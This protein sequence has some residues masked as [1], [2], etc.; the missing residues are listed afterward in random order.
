MIALNVSSGESSI[1]PIDR[2]DVRLS[3]R[4]RS[5]CRLFWSKDHRGPRDC[6]AYEELGF[7]RRSSG[8]VHDRRRLARCNRRRQ[9][10][11]RRRRRQQLEHRQQLESNGVPGTGDDVTIA[12][13]NTV[14]LNTNTASLKSLTITGGTLTANAPS[15]ITT[16]STFAV[17]GGTFKGS[18][19]DIT[20]GG[21]LSISGAGTSFTFSSGTTS[22]AG[23]Y[24]MSATGG[25]TFDPNG[26]TLSLLGTGTQS[27]TFGTKTLNRVTIGAD[28]GLV[29]Y[30][31][32]DETSGA[33]I[34]DS[35]GSG[36]NGSLAGGFGR[37]TPPPAVTFTDTEA[38]TFDGTAY[39]TLGVTG[40]PANNAPQSMSAWINLTS[41]AGVQNFV[42]LINGSSA[43]QLGIRNDMY[44]P[45]SPTPC[46]DVWAFGGIQLA[47][48]ALP[49]TGVWHHVAYTFDGTT[50]RIYMDGVAGTSTTT[51]P[52]T[53]TPSQVFLGSYNGTAEFL[54]GALD[55]VRV[56]NRALSP[57]E[58]STLAGGSDLNGGA[59]RTQT[60]TDAFSSSDD[61]VINVGTVT[62]TSALS[63][64]GSWINHGIFTGTGAVTLTGTLAG[65]AI[66]SNGSQFTSLTVN[67][68]GGTYAVID[69]LVVTGS[70]TIASGAAMGGAGTI[71]VGG[72]WAN[73][74]TFSGTGTVTLTGSGTVKSNG[75]RFA[76]LTIATATSSTYTT[77]DRLWVPGGTVTLTSGTLAAVANGARVG[78]FSGAGTFTNSGTLT[79][80]GASNQSL[81]FPS[82]GGALRMEDTTETGLVAYWKLDAGLGNQ[83]YDF[84]GNGNNGTLSTSGTSWQTGVGL[85]TFGFEN[86]AS[87]VFDGTTGSGSIPAATIPKNSAAQTVSFWMNPASVAGTE[88]VVVF[89]NSTTGDGIKIGIQGSKVTVW[90]YGGG[91]TLIQGSTTLTTGTWYHVVYTYDGANSQGLYVTPFTAGVPGTITTTT[92]TAANP[93][94]TPSYAH[95]GT[96]AT[97]NEL[98][99]GALD[100]VRV[101]STVLTAAQISQ[102]LLGNYAGTGGT[103]P[104]YTPSATTTVTG[105]LFVDN[106]LLDDSGKTITANGGLTVNTGG[107]LTLAA[108]SVVS[109]ASGKTLA[110]DGT[111][112]ASST[113]AIQAGSGHFTFKVGS[114]TSVTPTLNISGLTVKGTTGGMQI[115][116]STSATTTITQLNNLKFSGG[117]GAQYLLINAKSAYLTS[118]GCSFDAGLA[119]GA[120]TKA[121]TLAGNGTA[122][123]ETRAVFG[124][125]TC[126]KNWAISASDTVCTTTA[127]SDDDAD[128]NGI[129]DNP[130]TN[131]AVAQMIRAAE[132]DT[133]GSVVGFP[134]AA[135]D[136]NTF[137]YYSTYAAF[138]NASSGSADVIYVRDESGTPL[139][140]WTVPIAGETITGTPLWT[141]SGST[142]YLY[143][144]TSAGHV[145]RLIDT[146]TG[147]TS[148]TLSL[149]T[150]GVVAGVGWSTNPF[151]CSCTISTPLTMDASNLYWG[152]TTSDKSFWT[153]GQSTES[154]PTPVAITQTVTSTGLSV[155]NLSATT[156]YAFM[157][158]SGNFL[159]IDTLAQT[160]S[161]ANSS[162]GGASINGRVV[163]GYNKTGTWRAYGG[164]SSGT[165]WAL[166]PGAGFAT[167]NGLWSYP[168]GNAIQSSPYYDHDT[169][170]LQ[171][172]TQGGTIIVLNGASGTVLNAGYP[173]TPPGGGDAIQAAPLYYNGVLVVGSTGGK[174]Y[175]LDRNTGASRSVIKQ[176]SFGST[177][178]VSGIGFDPDKNRYMVTTANSSSND[179]RLYYFDLV[180]DPT[181]GSS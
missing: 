93:T 16:T 162:P 92:A 141:S 4:P 132:T 148:G 124:G 62:G 34:A 152:S 32:L 82:Y 2:G 56:Y 1:K 113:A 167:A 63:V 128:N 154:N 147:T 121:V 107:T 26:G 51:A 20:V 125:T 11:G 143:V 86:P 126:A 114:S 138:H 149:D 161:A 83:I 160:I 91:T 88:D 131:A 102:L 3:Y 151:D 173:Y 158:V 180:P 99:S 65:G 164:D 96:S 23:N 21:N 19:G 17:S 108:S 133:A 156:S 40:I 110:I 27:H 43:V 166:D 68:S 12:A 177:E 106:A 75:S 25:G 44:C 136:W 163:L 171:Y 84:S 73:S 89:D 129:G 37:T 153:L 142:H 74:G 78:K 45:T 120:T 115:G 50:H 176:Y 52:E 42:A 118:N 55:D 101:Y 15:T 140:A 157:A 18:S 127:K 35:S 29:G 90:T 98:Y 146:G 170:T 97:N 57:T 169:D 64:G 111:L 71:R 48:M 112:N 31:K 54:Q 9:D 28:Q 6:H 72:N 150:S 5:V 179:G 14:T 94:T 67:G 41:N 70:L 76:G 49:S 53:A 135:F 119:T 117:I 24:S 178:A 172:G 30:W 165:M 168:S 95:L 66:L 77:S 137:T 122:D 10:L 100:E 59:G 38:A 130:A 80:D 36:N 47:Y 144:A 139:Y 69:P 134:T 60:F 13:G 104:T 116:A 174:L 103:T 22:V 181:P 145:Y 109:I 123:G 61:L 87:V 46:L 175:F 8:G 159:K 105:Q 33:A 155:S 81:P 85:T 58:I 39:S 79:L 7:G